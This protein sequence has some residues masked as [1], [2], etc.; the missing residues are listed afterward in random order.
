MQFVF[1][2]MNK[3]YKMNCFAL[4]IISENLIQIIFLHTKF[5]NV[6]QR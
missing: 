5:I 4:S 6:I 3:P 2:V 1:N